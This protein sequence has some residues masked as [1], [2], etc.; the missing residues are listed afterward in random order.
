TRLLT[1]GQ[2]PKVTSGLELVKALVEAANDRI[3]IMPGSG[4]NS[5]NVADIITT[6][7]VNEVHTSAR[8]RVASSSTY[9]N[10]E[11]EEDYDIDFVDVEEIKRLRLRLRSASA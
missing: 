11:I 4:L 6:T 7:N 5:N 2:K 9:K 8:I 10:E 3:I 1:S